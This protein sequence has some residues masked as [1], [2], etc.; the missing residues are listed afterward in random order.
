MNAFRTEE[1]NGGEE[2]RRSGLD[3]AVC[4]QRSAVERPEAQTPT[5]DAPSPAREPSTPLMGEV[6][7]PKRPPDPRAPRPKTYPEYRVYLTEWL[8]WL[9][10]PAAI[11]LRFNGEGAL[12][13][14]CGMGK[15]EIEACRVMVEQ[16]I[17][18]L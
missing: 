11:G 17:G 8:A 14:A 15:E 5:P 12:W 13:A 10:D 6:M 9:D 7:P 16:R 3:G 2:G 1:L 18:Q 4:F